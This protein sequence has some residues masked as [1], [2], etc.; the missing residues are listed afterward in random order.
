M[1]FNYTYFIFSITYIDLIYQLY[2][3]ISTKCSQFITRDPVRSDHGSQATLSEVA[4]WM[5]DRLEISEKNSYKFVFDM[6]NFC[7][8][9]WLSTCC[10]QLALLLLFMYSDKP[11]TAN[12]QH[13]GSKT[14]WI[15]VMANQRQMRHTPCSKFVEN[16]CPL[17]SATLQQQ[18]R[19][20]AIREVC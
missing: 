20:V 13:I 19:Q 3:H 14:C 18:Q 8:N 2:R 4:T 1:C 11:L 7:W 5:G 10:W 16:K 6:L 17:F 15:R 12:T 9:L